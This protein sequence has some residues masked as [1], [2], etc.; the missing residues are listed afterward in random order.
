NLLGLSVLKAL[1]K[2]QTKPVDQIEIINEKIDLPRAN[3]SAR[4]DSM[5]ARRLR[6][7]QSLRGT[8]INLKS[9]LSLLTEHNNSP[10][11]PSAPAYRYMH[12]KTTE[13]K[14][15]VNMDGINE[16]E[17]ENY[18]NNIYIMEELIRI[19]ENLGLIRKHHAAAA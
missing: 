13:N 7:V 3:F 10:D 11:F 8:N 16:K 4:I 18:R 15:I 14:G 2:I 5:E 19:N 1:K 9:F 12:D 6:L 17:I